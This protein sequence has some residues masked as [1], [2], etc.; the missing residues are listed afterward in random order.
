MVTNVYDDCSIVLGVLYVFEDDIDGVF[1]LMAL[2]MFVVELEQ[3]PLQLQHVMQQ[4]S[5]LLRHVY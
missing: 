3:P 2:Q 1:V 4:P 5:L